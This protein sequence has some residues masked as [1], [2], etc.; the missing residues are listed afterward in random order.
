MDESAKLLLEGL[1]CALRGESVSWQPGAVSS[2][3]ALRRLAAAHSVLPLL[4]HAV[5][6]S[7]AAA[8]DPAAVKSLC[9][10]ARQLVISQARRTADFLLLYRELQ[11]HGLRPV[12]MKGII[13]RSLYPCPEQRP[14]VDEDL[15]VA[16]DAFMACHEL[17]LSLG[18][19]LAEQDVSVETE[20]EVSY[21]HPVTQ[22]YLEVHRSPFPPE[23]AAYGDFNA[24]FSDS[25]E[26]AVPFPCLGTTLYTLP[27]TDHLLFLIC[28]AHKHFLH[29]GVGIRQLCDIGMFAERYRGE[30][31]WPRVYRDCAAY[32]IEYIAAAFFRIA[33][34]HLG[35]S[36]PAVFSGLQLDEM[37]LLEDILAGGLY[38][39]EDEDRLR[40]GTLTLDAVAAE[41][42]GRKRRGLL[43]TL[44]PPSSTL[45]TRFPYLRK[46]P[47]LLPLAW[48]QRAVG[49]LKK[50]ELSAGSSIR[51]G[52]QRIAMLKQYHVID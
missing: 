38:G 45:A 6:D 14:S 17:L 24:L 32:R 40:S 43:A 25:L 19:R 35:F 18:F 21:R 5:W 3:P 27:P 11:R 39:T 31:D 28:H 10:R 47:W 50:K 26:K 7:P 48:L 30:I 52:E 41:R 8:S 20:S 9:A 37:P 29:S 33:E 4:A 36:M 13:C 46:R 51:I 44:F 34:K 1:S 2:W 15:L 49:Y 23:S 22:L 12:V 42:Q 16:P